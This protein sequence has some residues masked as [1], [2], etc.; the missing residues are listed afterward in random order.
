MKTMSE[1][2]GLGPNLKN[3]RGRKMT[4]QIWILTQIKNI[5]IKTKVCLG[6][7]VFPRFS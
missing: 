3:H 7:M 2:A 6:G 5:K 4:I 1:K